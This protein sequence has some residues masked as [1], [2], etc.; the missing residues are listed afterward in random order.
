MLS[1]PET[2]NKTVIPSEKKED[3][4]ETVSV[5]L[6]SYLRFCCKGNYSLM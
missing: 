3:A 4:E 2:V 1:L 5:C 6:L